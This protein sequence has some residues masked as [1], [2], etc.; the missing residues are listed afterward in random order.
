MNLRTSTFPNYVHV[1]NDA[2]HLDVYTGCETKII[3]GKEN[4]PTITQ[5][6]E[7][8]EVGSNKR[9]QQLLLFHI[10]FTITLYIV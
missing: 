5:T 1:A 8:N 3:E 2:V 10:M 6:T 9:D 4:A 7:T